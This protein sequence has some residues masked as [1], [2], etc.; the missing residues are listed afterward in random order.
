MVLIQLNC[1]LNKIYLNLFL[2]SDLTKHV[3][4][5]SVDIIIKLLISDI[6]SHEKGQ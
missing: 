1:S 4:G 3:K 6:S 5:Y 2:H